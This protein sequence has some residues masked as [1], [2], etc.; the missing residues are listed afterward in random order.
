MSAQSPPDE[1]NYS[2]ID[3]LVKDRVARV[4]L[5]RPEVANALSMKMRLEIIDALR[6][7]ES[8]PGISVVVV[9]ARGDSFCS[10]YD[11]RETYGSHDDREARASWVHDRALQ[12]WTDQFARSCVSDWMAVWDLLKPVVAIVQG[13]CLAGG[14]ELISFA[15]ITFAADDARL[16]YPP[17]RAMSTPD[18]P[19]FAWKMSMARAKYL[20]LSGNS[21]TGRTAAEWGWIAKSF[22]AETLTEDAWREVTAM[23]QIDASLLAA[24]KHQ[25]NQA[26]E[27]M[28]MKTHLTNS[29][30][31]HYLSSQA[32]PNHSEFFDRA[33]KDGVKQALSWMNKPFTDGG[34]L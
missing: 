29:W 32:R 6:R 17:M 20:Q 26:Y 4:T 31:W 13:N 33:A 25:V 19:F 3:Y 34:I 30:A 18:V 10:G 24:N 15:D 16:G 7:A 14:A 27:I 21:I 1:W 8:D 12:N 11:L 2:E 22:P 5:N 9:D 28:G 23:S